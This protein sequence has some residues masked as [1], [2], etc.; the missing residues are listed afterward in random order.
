MHIIVCQPRAAQV[1]VLDSQASLE[2]GRC[3]QK[4]EANHIVCSAQ[5]LVSA[6]LLRVQA[7]AHIGVIIIMRVLS[8][9]QV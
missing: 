6:W 7:F 9:S 1:K 4:S 3:C 2:D 8:A 5:I